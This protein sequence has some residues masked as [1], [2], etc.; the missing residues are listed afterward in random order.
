MRTFERGSC[1][2]LFRSKLHVVLAAEVE[3]LKTQAAVN[4]THIQNDTLR[5]EMQ[6]FLHIQYLNYGPRVI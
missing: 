2:L 1:S 5:H 3:I 6:I 4:I